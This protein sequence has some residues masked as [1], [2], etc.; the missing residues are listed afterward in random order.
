[1]NLTGYGCGEVRV[2]PRGE[3]EAS[4]PAADDPRV[5]A[6]L[7]EY[8]AAVQAGQAP[9]REAFLARHPEI[10][11]VLADCL[12]GLEWMRGAAP[13]AAPA[14]AGVGS[15]T[16]L[17]DY[18]LLR[19]I[20][21][22]GMGV[23]YEAEQ[24]SLRRRV[25]LK[26][27]PFAAALDSKQLQRFQNEARAA[28]HLHHGNIVPVHGVGCARGVHYYAMQFIEGQTVA[29]LVTELRRLAGRDPLSEKITP[30]LLSETV[31]RMLSGNGAA[32]PAGS[33]DPECTGP[34][35]S[36]AAQT[37][38]ANAVP[39]PAKPGW[40]KYSIQSSA[41][42]RTVAHLG[43][44]AAE[45]LE[46]AHRL[47]VIHR[48]IKP[49]NLLLEASSPAPSGKGDGVEGLRLWIT[50][51]GLALCQSQAGLSITSGLVGTLRY[52]SPE[53]ALAQRAVIDHRTDVYSLGATLYELLTLEPVF[54]GR[55]RQELLR[56]IAFEEPRRP[57]RL[58]KAIPPE[59]ETI[60]LKAM[61]RNP[62]ERYA[63]AQA[64]ADDLGHFL[65]DE[66]IRAKPPSLV[67]RARK[68]ERRH[69]PIVAAASLLLI[70]LG[71]AA[72]SFNPA[73]IQVFTPDGTLVVEVDDPA[74]KVTIEGDGGVVITGAGP[75]EV[76][77]RPGSYKVRATK[78]GTPVRPEELITITRGAKRVVK[79]SLEQGAAAARAVAHAA[80]G[81]FVVLNGEGVQVGEFDTL[82][83]AVLGAGAGDAIEVR[84]NGPFVTDPIKIT[85][86]ALTI[87]SGAGFRPVVKLRSE[88]VEAKTRLLETTGDL[89]V[90]G[91]EFQRIARNEQFSSLPWPALLQGSKALHVANCRFLTTKTH[92]A[93][94]SDGAVCVVRNCELLCSECGFSVY[95]SPSTP[96]KSLVVDNCV[97]TQ[98][99][100]IAFWTM[101]AR[102]SP[103]QLGRNTWR[104]ETAPFWF[105]TWK[106]DETDTVKSPDERLKVLRVE[107]SGNVF[108]GGSV[109]YWHCGLNRSFP[110]SLLTK[111]V[112][113]KGEGNVFAGRGPLVDVQRGW[114]SP[115]PANGTKTLLDWRRF[116]GTAEAHSVRGVVRYQGGDPLGRVRLTP[117][118]LT[119]EDFR[120]RPD[121]AGYRAGTDGKDLGADVDLVG[122]GKAY[123]RWKK[124][125]EYQQW[126]RETG[127]L[128]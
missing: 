6:A 19:E 82:A 50:D 85:Q 32:T 97:A 9:D 57:R 99:A 72:Y 66:P 117:E 125:P 58:N 39:D 18:R 77:L 76:R 69:R 26:V 44:Q 109:F 91:M 118:Q 81:A 61:E 127:Q 71:L 53:Q 14:G 78:E 110:E 46:H 104:T 56:Q 106:Q 120:L 29:G 60:V 12:D 68:C 47:G 21:R 13:V 48:D 42:F 23:V 22:G 86:P 98:A 108:D 63:T 37:R 38:D 49:G 35:G 31:G 74:V 8:Q 121:S 51:F 92:S 36:E 116:W 114:L 94:L 40:G 101:G 75:Q 113:W 24:L 95:M 100:R 64:F 89:V 123:E 122:P 105:L 83:D 5:I 115:E 103:V 84:G 65:R 90:E 87:R 62:A 128:K 25:A 80:P 17:G 111:L 79:V 73:V 3:A 45:A 126:L 11:A 15:G 119:P 27:L 4:G 20:G 7:E 34:Y 28:A 16:L 59:L 107:A 102:E 54:P 93:I 1:M 55:D 41:Y 70:A 124:T 2:S 30:A 33:A 112:G 88:A 67:Q 43:V 52:M 10:A 96:V